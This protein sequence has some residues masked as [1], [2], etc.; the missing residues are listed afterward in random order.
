MKLWAHL[1]MAGCGHAA[2]ARCVVNSGTQTFPCR[3]PACLPPRFQ[4]WSDEALVSVARRFLADVPALSDEL[5]ESV[6]QHMA[7]AH[8]SVTAASHK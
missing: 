3:L 4:P 2:V 6:A 8:Q 1:G 5:R 7:F